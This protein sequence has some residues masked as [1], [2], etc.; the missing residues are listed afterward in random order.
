VLTGTE[1]R[2]QLYVA[3]SRGRSTNHLHLSPGPIDDQDPAHPDLTPARRGSDGPADPLELLR[4]VLAR[5]DQRLSATSTLI[6]AA[7]RARQL[8][9]AVERYLD[10]H[11]L[12]ETPRSLGT[13]KATSGGPLHWLPPPPADDG[14]LAEYVQQ[15]ADLVH[16][17]AATITADHLPDTAWA[18]QLRGADPDLARRLAVWRAATGATDHPHPVGPQA[19]P[20]PAVRAELQELLAAHLPEP[21]DDAVDRSL[22]DR[23]SRARQ[24]QAL[25]MPA[26]NDGR[27]RGVSR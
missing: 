27:A 8:H 23:P 10:A 7:D 5:T 17:L 13:E 21:D 1:S 20:T 14:K 25:R 12:A 19:S 24:E 4:T 3:L 2:E 26:R 11:A 9:A 16:A 22:D 18:D 15:R 6:V